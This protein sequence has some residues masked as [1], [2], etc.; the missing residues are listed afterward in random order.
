MVYYNLYGYNEAMFLVGI[1]SWW[2][3]HGW[4]DRISM[5]VRRI[6]ST[7]DYFSVGRLILTLF[8][9][10]KQI[11]AGISGTSIDA[12]FRQMIDQLV[13]RVIGAFVRTFM[14]ILGLVVLFLQIIVGSVVLL[15]WLII[16]LFPIFGL[17]LSVVGWAPKWL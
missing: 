8:S 2:Y 16:P 4:S 15:L 7:S 12:K 3:G 9:P 17:L 13:S 6:Y 1:L 10:Y 14:I 5:I 11:S